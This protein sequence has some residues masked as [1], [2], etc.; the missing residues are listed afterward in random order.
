MRRLVLPAL[1]LTVL[2]APAAIAADH[3]ANWSRPAEPFRLLGDVY[4]VGTR[5]LSAFLVTGPAGHV[6]IDGALPS[7]APLIAESIR[8]LG[9]DPRDVKLILV[10]HSHYDHAGGLAALKRLTGAQ[11]L[12]SAGDKPDLEAGRTIGRADI[13]GFPPVR[14]DRV[15]RD[16]ER[17]TVG[18]VS[19]TAV[20]TPGHTRGATSWTTVSKGK[21]IIFASSLTVAGQKLRGDPAYPAAADDFRR[22]FAKL[23][24]VRAD[25]FVNFHPE[26][27]GLDAKRARQRGGNPDAFVDP[28]ELARQVD[29]AEAAFRTELAR[30]ASTE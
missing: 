6:L 18:P 28:A 27:F 22:T 30:Q 4:Y 1:T 3:P 16:G 5:G 26:G 24:A 17:V 12:A 20:L 2:A 9:F 25:V 7:S 8:R 15:I 29:A 11:L 10:N 19:L 14:V 21:R 13:E 23:R